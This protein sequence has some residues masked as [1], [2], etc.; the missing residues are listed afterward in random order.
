M[1]KPNEQTQIDFIVDCLR[2]GE[3]RK[4]IMGKF[5]EKWGTASKNTFDRRLTKAKEAL[6]GEQQRIKATAEQSIAKEVEARKSAIMTSI[7]RQELLTLIVR[8]EIKAK[9]PFVIG[10]KIMEYP[11][12]PNHS[13][14]IKALA[15]LNKMGGDY[16]PSKTD[17]TSDGKPIQAI[18]LTEVVQTFINAR[19]KETG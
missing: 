14:R 19:D 2:K 17:I 18:N 15:E 7:E 12:E 4:T 8:G 10:G 5:G 3:Q 16:A 1:P 13:D 6:S 9:R 11:E